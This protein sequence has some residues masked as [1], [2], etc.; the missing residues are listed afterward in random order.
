MRA[1]ANGLGHGAFSGSVAWQLSDAS[2]KR[3]NN[4]VAVGDRIPRQQPCFG[5]DN[6]TP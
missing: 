6:A 5:G 2:I 1:N 3:Y 4:Y